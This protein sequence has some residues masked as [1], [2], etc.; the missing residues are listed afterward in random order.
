MASDV[1]PI[2]EPVLDKPQAVEPGNIER[3]FDAIWRESSGAGYD[4]S[5]IR[6]RVVNLVAVAAD[7]A[8]ERRFERVMDVFPQRH[9]CR[10]IL[11]RTV[12]GQQGVEASIAAHCW[13]AGGSRH[14]C[15]EEVLLRGGPG[16]TAALASVVLSLLVPELPVAL[17]P[18]GLAGL[19]RVP[20]GL[21]EAADRIFIDTAEAGE[22]G[23]LLR[24]A[25]TASDDYDAEI[26]DLAWCRLNAWRSLLAQFFDGEAGARELSR[27]KSIEVTG[28]RAALSTEALLIAG[29]LVDR[30]DYAPADVETT[31]GRVRATLYGG[32]S[33]V[34]MS[35]ATAPGGEVLS[36]VRMRSA[37]AQFLVEMHESSGHIHVRQEWPDGPIDRTV[38]REAADDATL[39]SQALD[40][41][42]GPALYLGAA[43][44]VVTILGV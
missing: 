20:E 6:L 5:S 17:W 42:A 12:E 29:W 27:M 43:R 21:I 41:T 2:I 22:A 9:P 26:V 36:S 25:L 32:S 13:R 8:A 23:S 31:R 40:D 18:V 35:V 37:Q 44:R 38:E 14:L 15:S 33:G 7:E 24:A 1:A 19:V 3:A 34:S 39:L 16:D 4:D 10:G 11:A 28:G 30:L